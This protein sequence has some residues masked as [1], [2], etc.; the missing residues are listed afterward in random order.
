M[1]ATAPQLAS[2]STLFGQPVPTPEQRATVGASVEQLV[3]Q[4]SAELEALRQ[5]HLAELEAVNAARKQE[6]EQLRRL[7]AQQDVLVQR[8]AQVEQL[9]N[10]KRRKSVVTLL[11]L[12]VV[13]CG[14]AFVA[15]QVW[16]A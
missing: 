10:I 4:S 12:A 6:L 13:G 15:N 9:R 14:F 5:Q 11:G 1:T 16:R 2:S 7:Q 3:E 8:A